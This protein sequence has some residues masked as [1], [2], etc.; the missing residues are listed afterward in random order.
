MQKPVEQDAAWEEER[1]RALDRY[2]VLGTPPEAAFDRLTARLLDVPVAFLNFIGSDHQCTKSLCARDWSIEMPSRVEREMSVCAHWMSGTEDIAE[3]PDACLDKRF[4]E[5]PLVAMEDGLRFYAGALL[6]SPEGL[7]LGTLCVAGREP[8]HLSDE[9]RET[10]RE[11]AHIAMDEMESRA[12][13][14]EWG[15]EGREKGKEEGKAR[16][17][18][19]W[20]AMIENGSDIITLIDHDGCILYQSPSV[21]RALGFAPEEFAGTFGYEWVHPD[22][23]PHMRTA[24]A[25]VTGD[26]FLAPLP[27]SDLEGH[28]I[29]ERATE[30]LWLPAGSSPV[31]EIEPG[32][33]R[34]F[35]RHRHKDGSW[36]IMEGVGRALEGGGGAG[37]MVINSRDIT[38]RYEFEEQ[39]AQSEERHKSLLEHNADA[40]AV[41]CT[42]GKYLHINPAFEKMTGFSIEMVQGHEFGFS[43]PHKEGLRARA[44]FKKALSGDPQRMEFP[45]RCLNRSVID[46][47]I[48]A[49]PIVVR[50]EIVGVYLIGRDITQSKK[51]EAELRAAKLEA[52]RANRAKSEFLSRMSHEL[53]T[54][55]NAILG[56]GQLLEMARLPKRESDSAAQ[57]TKAGHHLLDLINEVLDISRIE[58]GS[59]ELNLEMVPVRTVLREAAALVAPLADPRHIRLREAQACCSA[60]ELWVQADRQ[61]LR[62]V[63]INL[64]SNAVKYNREDG[65]VEFEASAQDSQIALRVSDSGRGIAQEK[66]H[67]LFTPFERLG[68]E[69]SDIEGVGL[70]LAVS[71]RLIEAMDGTIHASSTLGKETTFTLRLPAPCSLCHPEVSG[72]RYEPGEL[73]PQ[74]LEAGSES[75]QARLVLYIEDNAANAL[76]MEHIVGN[77]PGLSLLVAPDAAQG[78]EAARVAQ[79]STILL[80]LNLPDAHGL[81]IVNELRRACPDACL[82][83]VSADA[84]CEQIESAH[85]VGVRRYFTKPLEVGALSEF[86]SAG[87]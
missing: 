51:A 80:D 40:I 75:P 27:E 62:Q 11:L 46:M 19:L 59:I 70:G 57:I 1:L 9:E 2:G 84:T 30:P 69:S 76:L 85:A 32:A 28:T 48:T 24:G 33:V 6:R 77:L 21:E 15:R 35:Y 43:M 52:E 68:A 14:L 61:R 10:L 39:L 72:L 12:H 8:R 83:I 37:R 60:E 50:G 79:P 26:K 49:V 13:A 3:V 81:S 86:L 16:S 17:E 64:F 23:Q 65:W 25:R 78:L 54:P 58:T 55:L 63:L 87:C 73:P 71:K 5:H 7:A 29:A 42:Q 74:V 53:R 36:R 44:L 31:E 20:R 82:A 45:V 66:L 47:V 22:D 34:A 18:E 56:F 41:V 67:R 38:Q 4:A